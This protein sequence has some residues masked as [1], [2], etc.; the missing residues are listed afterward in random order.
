LDL[1][2]PSLSCDF[3]FDQNRRFIK[4]LYPGEEGYLS[5][6]AVIRGY[7]EH[8]SENNGQGG[9]GA[10]GVN[11]EGIEMGDVPAVEELPQFPHLVFRPAPAR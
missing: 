8:E 2:S 5:D 7:E 11:G 9:D 1:D 3:Q 6:I 10:E 4:M